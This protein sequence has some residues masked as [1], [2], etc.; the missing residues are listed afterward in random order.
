MAL[1]GSSLFDSVARNLWADVTRTE[2]SRDIFRADSRQSIAII[3]ELIIPTTDTPGAIEAGIPKFIEHVVA[4]WYTD[5]ERK[6]FFAGLEALNVYC[7]KEFGRSFGQCNA[8]QQSAAL[9]EAERRAKNYRM[10]SNN[11]AQSLS[12]EID[13]HT[14]FFTKI[15]ELTVLGYYTSQ[16]GATTE[17]RYNPMPMR[18]EGDYPYSKVGKQWSW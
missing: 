14:P 12:A 18:Y 17:L 10:K 2:P 4:D 8:K 16:L 3:A 6:I 11:N 1:L 9:F 7:L 13:E 5:I 15:K